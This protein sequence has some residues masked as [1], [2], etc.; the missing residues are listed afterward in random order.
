MKII[1]AKKKLCFYYILI[2]CLDQHKLV[3][4]RRILSRVKFNFDLFDT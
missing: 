3:D 2:K 1:T 4:R